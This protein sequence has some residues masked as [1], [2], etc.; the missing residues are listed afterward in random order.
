MTYRL[1]HLVEA[2]CQPRRR[3]RRAEWLCAV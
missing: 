3:W 2:R 1:E